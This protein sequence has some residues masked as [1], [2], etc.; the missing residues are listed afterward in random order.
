MSKKKESYQD[1]LDFNGGWTRGEASHN[2][3]KKTTEQT[4]KSKK[5]YSR[6]EKHKKNLTIS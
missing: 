3:G 4:H 2:I 1:E 5:A 6:K